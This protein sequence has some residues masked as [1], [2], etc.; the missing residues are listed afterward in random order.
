MSLSGQTLAPELK[1][2]CALA[3][4]KRAK[5]T[6]I[7]MEYETQS[8]IFKFGPPSFKESPILI[9]EAEKTFFSKVENCNIPQ[10]KNMVKNALESVTDNDA[11]EALES[12]WY[13]MTAAS[14]KTNK[15]LFIAFYYEVLDHI[16]NEIIS[17]VLPE[18]DDY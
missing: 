9:T 14:K 18:D 2:F 16:E 11:R 6:D 17:D 7:Y 8:S 12:V 4:D 13:D 5:Y 10:I 3:R 15:N 1:D